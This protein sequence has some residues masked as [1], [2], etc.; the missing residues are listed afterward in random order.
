MVFRSALARGVRISNVAR[1]GW[2][3]DG[4]NTSYNCASKAIY[5]ETLGFTCCRG[6]WSSCFHGII[7]SAIRNTDA[8]TFARRL[9]T[10]DGGSSFLCRS[11]RINIIIGYEW[12]EM[13]SKC[14]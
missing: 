6:D 5:Q 1:G 9:S 11:A 3:G 2:V 10:T 4:C 7:R 14:P 12:M 13:V 8:A